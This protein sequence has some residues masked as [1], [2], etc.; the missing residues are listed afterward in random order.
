MWN[1]LGVTSCANARACA[2]LKRELVPLMV[3]SPPD[4]EFECVLGRYASR[5]PDLPSLNIPF[6][7]EHSV[8]VASCFSSIGVQRSEASC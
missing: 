7:D 5:R 3:E 2:R 6:R 4:D 8:T 1:G